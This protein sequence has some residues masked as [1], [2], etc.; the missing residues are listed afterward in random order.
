[1]SELAT[2]F[3]AFRESIEPMLERRREAE[4]A[5]LSHVA[6]GQKEGLDSDEEKVKAWRRRK[7]LLTK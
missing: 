2:V 7:K 3:A 5:R 6:R 1:M 4:L